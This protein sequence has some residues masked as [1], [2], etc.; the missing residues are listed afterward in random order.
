M[1]RTIY[2][3][4]GMQDIF[5]EWGLQQVELQREQ[6]EDVDMTDS[7]GKRAADYL[8]LLDKPVYPG[9]HYTLRKWLYQFVDITKLRGSTTDF[10]LEEMLQFSQATMN[11]GNNNIPRSY[12]ILK[13]IMGIASLDTCDWHVCGHCQRHA[14]KPMPRHLWQACPS[15]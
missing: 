8:H 7:S 4:D 10:V 5:L 2:S 6:G 14:W 3:V 12:Y 9:S 1:L 11:N 13:R 15:A